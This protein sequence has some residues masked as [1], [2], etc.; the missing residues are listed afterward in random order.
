MNYII[1]NVKDKLKHNKRKFINTTEEYKDT[2]ELQ[3]IFDDIFK[4]FK[5]NLHPNNNEKYPEKE[6]F[7][8][9]IDR[10]KRNYK[11]GKLCDNDEIIFFEPPD[12]AK[13]F[14]DNFVPEIFFEFARTDLIPGKDKEKSINPTEAHKGKLMTFSFHI[15]DIDQIKCYL[16][17]NGSVLR[18][19][20][21]D[22]I[23]VFKF[24]FI[25]KKFKEFEKIKQNQIIKDIFVTDTRFKYFHR[26]LDNSDDFV[27]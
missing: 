12:N 9:F 19:Y 6:R 17:W 3:R 13:T 22:I 16:L 7:N 23:D 26:S 18:F 15:I 10:R 4:K 11:L 5:Q 2:E 8:I 20:P 14:P 1:G 25:K 21:K 27:V 24:V